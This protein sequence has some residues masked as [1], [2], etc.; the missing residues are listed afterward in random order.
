[1]LTAKDKVSDR[2][3]SLNIQAADDY[4][5]KPFAFEEL[6]GPGSGLCYGAPKTPWARCWRWV[7]SKWILPTTLSHRQA[8]GI[9][10]SSREYA[11]MEYLLRNQNRI[12]D[13]IQHH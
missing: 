2:V 1:M 10:L 8:S 11:L 6:P 5:V 13:Q 12:P 9:S 3:A 7:T 4:L